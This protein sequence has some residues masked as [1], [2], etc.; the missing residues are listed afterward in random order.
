[1]MLQTRIETKIFK[2]V[3][4]GESILRKTIEKSMKS[5]H[6]CNRYFIPIFTLSSQ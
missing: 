5:V 4:S 2:L 3:A 6:F 1:M